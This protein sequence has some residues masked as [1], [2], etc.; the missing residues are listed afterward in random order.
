MIGADEREKLIARIVQIEDEEVFNG[1]SRLLEVELDEEIYVTT[2]Q[3]KQEIKRAQD[4]LLSGKG[5]SFVEANKEIDKWLG[6]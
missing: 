1:L 3:Q 6:V 2:D 4:Q 5:I